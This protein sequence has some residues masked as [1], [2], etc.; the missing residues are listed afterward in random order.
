MIRNKEAKLSNRF[1]CWLLRAIALAV[2]LC[3]GPRLGLLASDNAALQSALVAL[4]IGSFLAFL[5][6]SFAD[7]SGAFSRSGLVNGLIYLYSLVWIPAVSFHIF[8]LLKLGKL[9]EAGAIFIAFFLFLLIGF[10]C[11]A[12]RLEREQTQ[13]SA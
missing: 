12:R 10:S 4:G 5:A 7:L 1:G 9:N 13:P 8:S 3:V 2:L 11:R 6:Q